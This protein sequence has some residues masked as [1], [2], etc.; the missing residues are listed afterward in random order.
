L[1]I[2]EAGSNIVLTIPEARRIIGLKYLKLAAVEI[3][4]I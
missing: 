1:T 2:T 3:E 4:N